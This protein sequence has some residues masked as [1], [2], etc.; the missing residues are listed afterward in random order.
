M[1]RCGGGG[2]FK[3]MI[4]KFVSKMGDEGSEFPEKFFH[5]LGKKAWKHRRAVV[6][7]QPEGVLEA[8]PGNCVIA[9]FEVKN[10]T[11]WPWKPG[12]QLTL[13]DEQTEIDIPIEFFQVPIDQPLK[14]GQSQLF[15]VP[16]VI[17]EHVVAS[18]K[19]FTLMFTFRGPKGNAFGNK[20]PVQFKVTLPQATFTEVDFYKLAIKLHE[21]KLGSVE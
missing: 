7:K 18:D 4:S 2:R 17:R 10:D 8:S 3:E 13:D 9:T 12:C 20:I 6:T 11:Q 19:I 21:A 5:K 16:L 14:G 15:E 1:G